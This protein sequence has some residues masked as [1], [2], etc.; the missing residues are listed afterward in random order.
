MS[1]PEVPAATPKK[2]PAPLARITT[3]WAVKLLRDLV[4][5]A[6]LLAVALPVVGWLR[7][8]DLPEVAPSF[9]LQDLNGKTVRLEDYRGKVV[10]VNF[11]ATWCGPC[12]AEIPTFSAFAERNPDIPVLGIAV[13]G[14]P[15]QLRAAQKKMGITYPILI[16]D[17]ATTAAYGASTLP[18]TIIVDEE[19]KI[20][21]AH[22]GLMLPPHLWLA[23]R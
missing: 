17:K 1:T 22:T 12:R 20:S 19:G 3:H 21:S 11:W 15:A 13:D 7:A 4:I 18:T 6:V 10:V 23:T 2:T 16:G 9:A 8:P 14:T 5:G